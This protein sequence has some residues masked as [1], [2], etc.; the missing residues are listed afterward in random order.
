VSGSE[1]GSYHHAKDLVLLRG[2]AANYRMLLVG[3]AS[4]LCT[5]LALRV[6][7]AII[8]HVGLHVAQIILSHMCVYHQ[9]TIGRTCVLV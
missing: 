8:C 5:H 2:I 1:V 7:S 3:V 6:L 9:D 4:R